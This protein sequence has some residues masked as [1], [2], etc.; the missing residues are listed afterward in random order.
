M[1]TGGKNR[2]SAELHLL[3][4]TFRKQRH[5]QA[6][7]PDHV[8]RGLPEPPAGLPEAV[9][10]HW[11]ITVAFLEAMGTVSRVDGLVVEQYARLFTETAAIAVTQAET[12]ASVARLEE[13][14]SGLEGAELVQC[15]QEITK[16]R[17]LEARYATQIR[18]GRMAQRQ[19]L[20]E[21]CLT[22][23]SRV[24]GVRR[25]VEPILSVDPKKQRYLDALEKPIA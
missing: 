3:R 23:A 2:K 25:T 10:Q 7:I 11:H 8:P 21:L 22:P 18:Q 13:N 14:L 6:P 20:I 4:A 9:L 12:A 5:G 15:F 16:L 24:R 17:Q 1:R 19:Y